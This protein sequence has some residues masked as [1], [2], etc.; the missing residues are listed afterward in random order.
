MVVNW[1]CQLVVRVV[2]DVVCIIKANFEL[3]WVN[4]QDFPVSG[5][6][7]QYIAVEVLRAN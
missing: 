7:D 1:W 2:C 3:N 5:Q 6:K 4:P